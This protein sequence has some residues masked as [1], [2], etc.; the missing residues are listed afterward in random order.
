M[1]NVISQKA[2]SQV[3]CLVTVTMVLWLFLAG[4]VYAAEDVAEEVSRELDESRLGLAQ[5][6]APMDGP[7]EDV[8]SEATI[9]TVGRYIA[10]VTDWIEEKVQNSTLIRSK[11]DERKASIK[12]VDGISLREAI[13]LASEQREGTVLTARR[14]EEDGE[15]HFQ[16]AILSDQGVVKSIRIEAKSTKAELDQSG[17]IGKQDSIRGLSVES[18]AQ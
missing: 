12:K 3:Y 10:P 13:R 6:P 9:G 7:K 5:D 1:Y 8:R 16:V 18:T 4:P 17:S 11:A 15:V 2:H 14:V